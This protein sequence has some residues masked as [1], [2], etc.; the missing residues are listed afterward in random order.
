[1]SRERHP[2]KQRT[3]GSR[4]SSSSSRATST[5]G[6]EERL[7]AGAQADRS[8]AIAR[9][10]QAAEAESTPVDI[11]SFLPPD[12]SYFN[13]KSSFTSQSSFKSQSSFS[14][15]S[16]FISQPPEHQ[17]PRSLVPGPAADQGVQAHDGGAS[18]GESLETDPAPDR[19]AVFEPQKPIP[20][21]LRSPAR[22]MPKGQGPLRPSVD[23]SV[24]DEETRGRTFSSAFS[25]PSGTSKPLQKLVDRSRSRQPSPAFSFEA[26]RGDDRSSSQ[27]AR[28]PEEA[29]NKYD[30]LNTPNLTRGQRQD[31]ITLRDHY[32][33][34]VENEA[35]VRKMVESLRPQ[36]DDSG[37]Y[38]EDAQYWKLEEMLV[39]FESIRKTVEGH[40]LRPGLIE[41]GHDPIE[42]AW[43]M[44]RQGALA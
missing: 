21:L 6:V 8:A 23:T 35:S 28:S 26:P 18:V 37:T 25:G 3:A 34:A 12:M 1:M 20:K 14:S 30:Y 9:D 31:F 22:R 16:S 24:T 19:E 44:I 29:V 39:D 41:A 33:R 43:E 2:S 11:S 13:P 42:A 17:S 10:E 7:I 5:R 4:D 40:R 15:Q 38:L 36:S 32:G 27:P